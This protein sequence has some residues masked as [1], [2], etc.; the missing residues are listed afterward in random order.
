MQDRA[1]HPTTEPRMASQ[2]S[3][4]TGKQTAIAVQPDALPRCEPVLETERIRMVDF[5]STQA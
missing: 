5:T 4:H 1:R 3:Q 2:Q